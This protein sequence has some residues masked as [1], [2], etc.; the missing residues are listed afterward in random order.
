MS[1]DGLN[2][3]SLQ[4]GRILGKVPPAIHKLHLHNLVRVLII[5]TGNL[6]HT[7]VMLLHA[8]ALFFSCCFSFCWQAAAVIHCFELSQTLANPEAVCQLHD[9]IWRV[10]KGGTLLALEDCQHL[11]K[12]QIQEGVL[13]Q[14]QQCQANPAGSL[15]YIALNC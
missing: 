7:S 15:G 5:G 10:C 4:G 3:P 2:M 1:P 14:P 6:L 11:L 13:T 12:G 8:F 9:H